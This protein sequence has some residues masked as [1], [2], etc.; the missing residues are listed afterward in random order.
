MEVAGAFRPILTHASSR[1][2]DASNPMRTKKTNGDLTVSAIAGTHVVLLAMDLPQAACDGLLGFAIHRTEPR[3]REAI[4]LQGMKIFRSVPV[5]FLPGSKVSTRQHPIQAFTWSDFTAKPATQ[6]IYR[7]V[8][9]KGTPAAPQEWVASEVKVITEGESLA[10]GHEV[11]FNRGT[12]ASQEYA[13]RFH[14]LP[15]EQAGDAAFRWLS[16]GLHE[17]LIGFI[18]R[19]KD[20]DWGLRVAAYEFTESSVLKALKA[21]RDRQADVQIIYHA[22][23]QENEETDSKGRTKTTQTGANRKAVASAGIGDICTERLAPP[24]DAISHNKYIVLLFKRKPVAVLTGSTNFSVGGIFGHSNVVHIVNQSNVAAQYL[25]YWTELHGD[26]RTK[27]L[28]V[29]MDTIC[30]VPKAPLAANVPAK[31]TATIFSPRSTTDALDYYALLSQRAT[32]GLFMTFA[33]GMNPAFQKVYQTSKA[34]LRMTLMEKTALPNK[35]KVKQAK[36]EQAIID[37]RRM[38]ENRFAIG[39]TMP[40]NVLEHWADE[41][42][43]GL[44]VNVKYLHTKYML[45][46]P[47]SNDPIVV[48]G[49][50]NFSTASCTDNDENMLVIRGDTRVADIYLGEF[51]RLYKHFAFRDWLNHAL[52]DGEIKPGQPAPVEF[53]DETNTWWKRW[54]GKTGYSAEREYFTL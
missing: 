42:L 13:S 54:F 31:G 1:T 49:S 8:A 19:A 9:L 3:S 45:V 32:G 22:R 46:D 16:R 15:P 43:S 11:Y 33:F 26:P 24:K 48:S 38:P 29:A 34:G 25:A 40:F 5:D 12:A 39:G 37:L 51:I 10:N 17:S 18:A 23:E 30:S 53:L 14:N 50:A 52:E 20:K 7:V 44:N 36:E 28:R 41:K 4:W 21:A 35:D 2:T 6:Y 47:L 27:T